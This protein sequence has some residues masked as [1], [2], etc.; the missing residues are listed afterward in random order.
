MIQ[1]QAQI[2]RATLCKIFFRVK[3]LDIKL[4]LAV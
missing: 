2:F 3:I 4:S 1:N